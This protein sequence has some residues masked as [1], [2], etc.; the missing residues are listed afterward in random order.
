MEKDENFQKEYEKIVE[1]SKDV[2]TLQELLGFNQIK[3]LCYGFYMIGQEM[4]LEKVIKKY[5]ENEAR[6]NI[7]KV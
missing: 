5:K 6:N 4:N 2:A 7:P 3:M 1:R